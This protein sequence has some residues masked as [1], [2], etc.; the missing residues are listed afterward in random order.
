MLLGEHIIVLHSAFLIWF[1]F[2]SELFV[3]LD[4]N[5]VELLEGEEDDSTALVAC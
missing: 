2:S 1:L 5:V 4:G 3:C